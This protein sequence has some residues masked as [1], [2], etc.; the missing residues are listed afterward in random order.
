MWAESTK[1]TVSTNKHMLSN[2]KQW[3]TEIQSR[4]E[5]MKTCEKLLGLFLLFFQSSEKLW[6]VI[7]DLANL[8]HSAPH[9]QSLALSTISLSGAHAQI[10]LELGSRWPPTIL[11]IINWLIQFHCSLFLIGM[12]QRQILFCPWG[13]GGID[14]VTLPLLWLL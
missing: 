9:F 7:N 4:T 12:G 1:I 8:E 2:L 5:N 10:S 14:N 3:C 6:C 11:L 13:S